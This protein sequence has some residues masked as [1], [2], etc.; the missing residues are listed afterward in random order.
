MSWINGTIIPF[1]SKLEWGTVAD[2]VSG[3]GSLGAIIFA[4]WQM[5]VQ[6]IKKRKIK[7]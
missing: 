5:H 6:K 3:I 2:W 7:Y 4:Y 1:L